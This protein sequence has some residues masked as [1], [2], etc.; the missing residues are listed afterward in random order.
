M[1]AT[2]YTA[3]SFNLPP[4]VSYLNGHFSEEIEVRQHARGHE[5][6]LGGS[7]VGGVALE[8]EFHGN[9]AAVVGI[10]VDGN[11]NALLGGQNVQM[12]QGLKVVAEGW[13]VGIRKG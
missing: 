1:D 6:E 11:Q 3:I 10:D 8:F 7:E 9:V 4:F 12:T 2:N 5:L 13:W